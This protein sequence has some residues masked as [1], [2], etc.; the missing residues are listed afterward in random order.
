MRIGINCLQI[1][2]GYAGGVNTYTLGLLEGFAAAGNGCQFRLYVTQANQHL[3]EKFRRPANFQTTVIDDVLLRRNRQFCLAAL[4]SGSKRV[5]KLT[6]D[7]AF[8]NIREMANSEVD[9]LYVPTVV[10]PFFHSQKPT[11]LSMHDI[12]HVH[13]PEFFGWPRRLSREITYGLSARHASYF[14]ASSN[15]IKEDLLKH[16]AEIRPDQVEVIPEGVNIEEFAARDGGR[17]RLE[18]YQLP[19]KFLFF[20]A[21][22]WPHKNHL[23][24]LK[25]LKQIEDK[26]GLKIPLVLTG[27]K[28]S[29]APKIFEFIAEQSMDYVH[30]LGK[31]PLKNLVALF[32][33]AAIL[34]TAVLY[35][36]SSLPILEAAAAGT[37]IIASRTPPNEELSKVLQ[38]NLFNPL[39]AD[40]LAEL[41][42]SLWHD[43]RTAIRQAAHNRKHIAFYNW[44]N[45]ARKYVLLFQRI[46]NA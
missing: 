46:V 31:V 23:T 43:E 20:P 5:Y 8:E 28:F 37:P 33:E 34:L 32:Q 2:P 29:A 22:L 44:E 3:F 42:L 13:Y 16:F 10:L 41:I 36:S 24:V 12:Q 35:E 30:Y 19:E 21:Q 9:L 11:V 39:D 4:L 14:Q 26:H 18:P 45:A 7:F 25:A 17:G 15:F 1:D 38:L 40:A 6:S 27:A